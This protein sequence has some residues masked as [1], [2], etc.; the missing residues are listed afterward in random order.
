MKEA[1]NCKL[2]Q[3][4]WEGGFQLTKNID[5]KNVGQTLGFFTEKMIKLV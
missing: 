5:Q 4:R 1:T 2:I 3:N